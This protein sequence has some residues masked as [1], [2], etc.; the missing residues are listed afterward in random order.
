MQKSRG[1]VFRFPR[2]K[3][4]GGEAAENFR[5][6]KGKQ[7]IFEREKLKNLLDV[8]F[9]SKFSGCFAAENH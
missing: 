2:K 4:I 1:R 9:T 7:Q 3:I 5:K 8:I 6:N